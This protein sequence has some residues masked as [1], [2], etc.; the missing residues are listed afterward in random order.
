MDGKTWL[1]VG[2]IKV[3]DQDMKIDEKWERCGK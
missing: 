1:H 3:N 2:K